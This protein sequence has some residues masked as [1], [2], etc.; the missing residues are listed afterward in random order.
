VLDSIGVRSVD[1]TVL[2]TSI[3]TTERRCRRDCCG[4]VV[5]PTSDAAR[6][7][8]GREPAPQRCRT[9][10]AAARRAAGSARP[11][12]AETTPATQVIVGMII[13]S[14]A[15]SRQGSSPHSGEV[16]MS[17]C[18]HW[19]SRSSRRSRLASSNRHTRWLQPRYGP[20]RCGS[21]TELYA[22][23][24]VGRLLLTD[25][26]VDPQKFTCCGGWCRRR[27]RQFRY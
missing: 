27:P 21:R 23:L 22:E 16:S 9:I 20:T 8:V 12:S 18:S 4:S 15:P 10:A 3:V 13:G 25:R 11:G 24:V 6:R 14:D 7:R 19:R 5:L 26:A 17:P 1:R 2:I